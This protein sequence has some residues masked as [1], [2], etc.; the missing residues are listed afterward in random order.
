MFLG[1]LCYYKGLEVLIAA[2]KRMTQRATVLII[3]DGPWRS[4]LVRQAASQMGAHVHF[5]GALP[6]EEVVAHLHAAELFVFPSTARSEAFGLAQLKAM[7]C[8]LPVVSTNLPGVAWVNRDGETGLTVPP[9]DAVALA[10]SVDRLL[11]DQT[12]RHLLGGGARRRA[13]QFGLD[14]MTAGYQAVYTELSGL[15][16]G[17]D[18]ATPLKHEPY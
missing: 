6:E 8:G 16:G 7:A 5:T 1:R 9:R 11:A 15:G 18:V 10:A 13:D 14:R 12:L 2:A 17:H 4:R 3:G